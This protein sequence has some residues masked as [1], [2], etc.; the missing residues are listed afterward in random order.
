ML[1]VIITKI[2]KVLALTTVKKKRSIYLK[3]APSWRG[4]QMH[5]QL[6]NYT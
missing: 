4:K 3:S 5:E 1:S 2:L 6:N